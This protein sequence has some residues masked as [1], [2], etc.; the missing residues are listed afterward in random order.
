M[1]KDYLAILVHNVRTAREEA[2]LLQSEIAERTGLNQQRVSL[3]E[4]GKRN[5][6]LKILIALAAA[7]GIEPGDLL[8]E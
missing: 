6:T 8:T 3:I 7:F 4:A 1:S 5:I 2:G